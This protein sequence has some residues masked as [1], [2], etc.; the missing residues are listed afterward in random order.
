M[1]SVLVDLQSDSAPSC[2]KPTVIIFLSDSVSVV[3][4]ET[5]VL[6]QATSKVASRSST[7]IR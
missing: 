7:E 6:L 1:D 4:S 2:E 3:D 5:A